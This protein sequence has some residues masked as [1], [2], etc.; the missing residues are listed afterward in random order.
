MRTESSP[1]GQKP[2]S[3]IEQ[4]RR[5]QIIESAAAVVAELGYARA[6][7]ARIA[8]H[9]G[10][11]KGVVTYH[12][13]SKDEIFHEMVTRFFDRGWEFM[14]HRIEEQPSATGQIRA[15]ISAEIEF[16]SRHRTEFLAMSEVMQNH[17][18]ADGSHAFAG[19]VAEATAGLAEILTA[20]QQAGELR[21]FDPHSVARILSR[22]VEGVLSSWA[23]HPSMDLTAET[24]TLL[25][26]ISHAIRKEPT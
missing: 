7:L 20:G 9:A 15:W 2:R 19:E 18:G 1:E 10:I 21:G 5:T 17:R 25:D 6:S 3:F 24:A 11:S 8:E 14:A 4:A 13:S 26:L 23:V 12:F 22:C 16:F